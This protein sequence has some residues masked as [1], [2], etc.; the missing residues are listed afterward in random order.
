MRLEIFAQFGSRSGIRGV[1]HERL[2]QAGLG[3]EI[4]GMR[5]KDANAFGAGVLVI[6]E[7]DAQLD[8]ITRIAGVAVRQG[9][10]AGDRLRLAGG[11]SI[12]GFVV[13]QGNVAVGRMVAIEL[14]IDAHG[15]I[16]LALLRQLA[17]LAELAAGGECA[18]HG[19]DLGDVGVVRA[20]FAQ[21]IESL[22]GEV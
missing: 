8:R 15:I 14:P 2:A 5:L 16:D 4:G 9:A 19:L 11:G 18:G 21:T 1:P 6:G 12:E 22:I 7:H 13:S 20:Y 17:C 10:H 3:I